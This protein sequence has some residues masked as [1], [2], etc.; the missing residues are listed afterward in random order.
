MLFA[1]FRKLIIFY[2]IIRL[3][4]FIICQV[5][6]K[7]IFTLNTFKKIMKARA[8]TLALDSRAFHASQSC[9]MHI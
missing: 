6:F 9:N 7:A 5:I 1:N 2:I 8:F 3:N 4:I